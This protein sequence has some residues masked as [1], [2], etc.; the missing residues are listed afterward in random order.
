MKFGA[1]DVACAVASAQFTSKSAED[2]GHYSI[3]VEAEG[4]LILS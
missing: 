2:S 4:I 3:K 1:S